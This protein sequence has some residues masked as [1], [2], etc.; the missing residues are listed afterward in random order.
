MLPVCG[1]GEGEYFAPLPLRKGFPRQF[2]LGLA[3]N[4]MEGPAKVEITEKI[5][6]AGVV[7]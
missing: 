5:P 1:C 3:S 6:R 2:V 7:Q 4:S